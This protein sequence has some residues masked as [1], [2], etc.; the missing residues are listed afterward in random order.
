MTD[1]NCQDG[2]ANG[3]EDR[4]YGALR[5]VIDPEIGLDIVTLGLVY[6]VEINGDVVDIT[7]SLTTPGCPMEHAIRGGILQAV[8]QVEGIGQVRPNLVWE[9]RWDPSRVEPGAL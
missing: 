1:A 4:V 7:F 8:G 6:N 2:I 3:L 9:P 5:L